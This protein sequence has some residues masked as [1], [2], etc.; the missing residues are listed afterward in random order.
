MDKLTRTPT[1]TAKAV[2]TTRTATWYARRAAQ[3][4]RQRAERTVGKLQADY[5][6]MDEALGK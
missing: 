6:A 4:E 5:Q 3:A 2:V 1:E